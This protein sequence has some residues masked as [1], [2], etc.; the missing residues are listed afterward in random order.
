MPPSRVALFSARGREAD[1]GTSH[2][3]V[4]ALRRNGRTVLS[5]TI[6]RTRHGPLA[7]RD[8]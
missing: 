2:T 4:T 1:H 6:M 5:K 3:D 7:R 8:F